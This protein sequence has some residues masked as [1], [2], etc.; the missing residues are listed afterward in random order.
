MRWG[1]L[2]GSKRMSPSRTWVGRVLVDIEPSLVAARNALLSIRG[3]YLV[4]VRTLA[5]IVRSTQPGA[6][7]C[8]G[9]SVHP[10]WEEPE[11]LHWPGEQDQAQVMEREDRGG[12]SKKVRG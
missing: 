4:G 12:E 7:A 3:R 2:W 1:W 6:A 10:G 9:W 11:E 8:P 5:R